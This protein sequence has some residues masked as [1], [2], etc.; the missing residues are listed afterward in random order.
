MYSERVKR[1]LKPQLNRPN[2]V[3]KEHGR[4]VKIHG[5]LKTTPFFQI[6]CGLT[7]VLL[8]ESLLI[9]QR[10]KHSCLIFLHSLKNPIKTITTMMVS[11]TC[12]IWMMTMTASMICLS[13]S[14]DVTAPTHLTTTMTESSMQKIGMTTTTEFSKDLSM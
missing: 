4:E 7:R 3:D 1:L 10:L 8:Q 2:K 13:D 14:T 11:V 6:S 5:N 9:D 12:M